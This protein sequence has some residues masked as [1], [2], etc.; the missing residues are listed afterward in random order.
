VA[1]GER[2]VL[3]RHPYDTPL[4]PLSR[5]VLARCVQ[6]RHQ[7]LARYAEAASHYVVVVCGASTGDDRMSTVRVLY[8]SCA[9]W[10]GSRRTC[11]TATARRDAAAEPKLSLTIVSYALTHQVRLVTTT[12]LMVRLGIGWPRAAVGMRPHRP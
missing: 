12:Q 5:R 10:C 11:W 4:V 8:G 9:A 7:L 1:G 6:A 2:A 3:V